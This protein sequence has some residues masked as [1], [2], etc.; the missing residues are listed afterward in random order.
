MS[1][2]ALFVLDGAFLWGHLF[3]AFF[4]VFGWIPKLT[5]HVHRWC[6]CITAFCWLAVGAYYNN[7]GY[8]PLTDWH[9]QIKRARG[10]TELPHSFI[11]Y[12]LNQVGIFPSPQIVDAVVG[13]IFFAVIL[14]TLVL[15]LKDRKKNDMTMVK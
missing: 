12:I 10:E 2:F 15:W 14:I 4:N 1:P 7:I 6:V 9:W 5:R 13:A 8:C 3:L 11:T